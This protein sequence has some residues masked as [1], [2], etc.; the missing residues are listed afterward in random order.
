[1]EWM[2]PVLLLT[3]LVAPAVLRRFPERSAALLALVPGA[4]AL[5]AAWTQFAVARGE[6]DSFRA[7]WVPSLGLDWAFR[8]DGLANLF[9]LLVAGIGAL[10]V[11]YASSYLRGHPRLGRFYAFLF[12]FMAAMLGVVTADDLLLL[13]V[14]WELTTVSSFL[15]IGF[16]QEREAA[17]QA[18]IRSLVVTGAGG[19]ALLLAGPLQASSAP[20]ADAA[21]AEDR[22]RALALLGDTLRVAQRCLG[23]L[24]LADVADERQ[25]Q[26]ALFC[27]EEA[28]A[29]L[30]RELA[31]IL[32]SRDQL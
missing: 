23:A 26:Q 22:A 3:A 15:L 1:M 11:V 21:Q 24:A 14:F 13:F 17:R 4:V 5:H 9:V 10:I 18:A 6:F 28:Q 19:L 30:D 29:D 2:L 27:L 32:A 7:A 20:L 16:Q 12:V 31:S 25:G 8:V